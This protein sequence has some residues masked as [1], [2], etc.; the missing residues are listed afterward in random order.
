MAVKKN[1]FLSERKWATTLIAFILVTI[2]FLAIT[3][4]N[5][6]APNYSTF[7][8]AITGILTAYGTMNVGHRFVLAKHGIKDPNEKQKNQEAEDSP[9]DRDQPGV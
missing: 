6:L 3:I 7:V 2:G 5:D 4:D 1:F 9:E 8:M